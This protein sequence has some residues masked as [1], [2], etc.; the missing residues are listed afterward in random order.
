MKEEAVVEGSLASPPEHKRFWRWMIIGGSAALAV[1]ILLWLGILPWQARSHFDRG[2]AYFKEQKY[3]EARRQ[4]LRFLALD[5]RKPA[6]YFY[7]GRI[8]LGV[9]VPESEVFYPEANYEEAIRY[10]EKAIALGLAREDP[11]LHAQALGQSAFSYWILKDY[12]NADRLYLQKIQLYPELSFFARYFVALDY[13]FRFNRPKEALEI[14]LKAPEAL[15]VNPF[16]L[17]RVYTLIARLYVYQNDLEN[18]E[19]YAALALTNAPAGVQDSHAQIAHVVLGYVEAR[20]GNLSLA[21]AEIAKAESLAGRTGF[22]DC[23]LAVYY[24]VNQRYD[25]ALSVAHSAKIPQEESYSRS[26]CLA[27]LGDASLAQGSTPEAKKYF[28]E[29]LGLT[30]TMEEKNIFVYR[31]QERIKTVLEK[32]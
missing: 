12:E 31:E 15:D 30:D 25:V 23:S 4:F 29:Y 8:A 28:Q 32:L 10:Y 13:F 20:R 27:V 18:A 26:V 19:K 9:S 2:L 7:L 24:L 6:T 11:R 21:E 5:D 3:P 1:F 16:F 22:Y 14:L 17:Y